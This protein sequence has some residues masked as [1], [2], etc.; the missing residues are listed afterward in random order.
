MVFRSPSTAEG[1]EF[2]PRSLLLGFMVDETVFSGFSSFPLSQIS[3]HHFSTLMSFISLR[4]LL[5]WCDRHGRSESLLFNNRG[6]I[7]SNPSSRNC[8]GL[9][10]RRFKINT[11]VEPELFRQTFRGCSGAVGWVFCYE[12][13]MVSS[14]RVSEFISFPRTQLSLR[15]F[16][17][18]GAVWLIAT[19]LAVVSDVY[20]EVHIWAARQVN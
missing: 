17:L 8:D 10:L 14:C 19:V 9:G 2:A 6:F 7:V 1:T 12:E 15:M 11:R 16:S 4:Q 5:S 3:F 13:P 18:L 20:I